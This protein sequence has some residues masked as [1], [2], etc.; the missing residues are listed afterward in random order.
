MTAQLW[1]LYTN[2]HNMD[3]KQEE[4]EAI[5]QTESNNTIVTTETQWD[6]SYD[7][8][9]AIDGCKLF[10]RDKQEGGAWGVVLY[11]EEW[12]DCTDLSL[13]NGDE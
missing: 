3:N 11:V 10:R 8:N 13:K 9:I 1:C 5:V 12:F 2:A 6:E 7:C 4:L